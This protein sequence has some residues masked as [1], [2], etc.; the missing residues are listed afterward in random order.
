MTPEEFVAWFAKRREMP[1]EAQWAE[2]QNALQ[3]C[4]AEALQK[5]I[6]GDSHQKS[7]DDVIARTAKELRTLDNARHMAS[8]SM[9]GY[10][11][12]VL[13]PDL[14]TLGMRNKVEDPPS[15]KLNIP[16]LFNVDTD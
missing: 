10:F 5:R 14:S 12:P 4:C 16:D 8:R 15:P 13:E 7:M 1:S 11:N 2:I 9:A 3:Q 6:D